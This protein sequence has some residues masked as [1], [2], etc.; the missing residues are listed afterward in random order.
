MKKIATTLCLTAL[1]TLASTVLGQSPTPAGAT[2]ETATEHH[3]IKIPSDLR[4]VDGPPSLPA[5]AKMVVLEGDP[6]KPGPFTVRFQAPAGYKIPAHT[7]PTAEQITVI[8][9]TLNFGMGDKVDETATTKM[10][11]GSFTVMPVGM[12]H[13]VISKEETVVQ[14]SST[15][16]FEINYVNPAD[17]PRKAK[18]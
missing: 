11:P 2:K 5:G 14:V 12:K 15:G 18:K 10:P 4:W 16:P 9:G 7:H 3:L 13:F 1:W 6:E 17:D 8:S